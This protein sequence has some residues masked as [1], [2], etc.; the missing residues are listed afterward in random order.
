MPLLPTLQAALSA[1]PSTSIDLND[2]PGVRSEALAASAG[3]AAMV[4]QAGPEVGAVTTAQVEVAD[5][6]IDVRI[7]Q[8]MAPG[9]HPLHIYFHGGGWIAGGIEDA[10]T[11]IVGRERAGLAGYVTVTVDYRLAPEVTFPVPVDDSYAALLWAVEHAAEFD[12]DPD[13]VTL[14]GGSAGA[15]IAAAVA[16]RASNE[17]GPVISLQ[18]LEVPALDLT[19]SSDSFKRYG[20]G[21]YPL[22]EKEIRTYIGLYLAQPLDGLNEFASPLLTEDPTRFPPT[23]VFSSEFDP[24]QDDGR[25]F[26]EL[27][28]AAGVEAT[29]T[30][31]EGQVHGSSGFTKLLPESAT[32]RDEIIALLRKHDPRLTETA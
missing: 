28:S 31:G 17:G 16:L 14:G 2:I 25:R 19:C 7:Y 1:L 22:S 30:L 5:G 20:G 9:P 4:A 8:P 24:L 23:H 21:D 15:N 27:L 26:V 6:T 32:W 18:I 3:F 10:F 12:A 11:D 29:F 13:R